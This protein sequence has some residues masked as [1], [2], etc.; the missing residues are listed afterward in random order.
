MS[1]KFFRDVL[2]CFKNDR[3][4]HAFEKTISETGNYGVVSRIER[5]VQYVFLGVKGEIGEG[6]EF[7]MCKAM[8]DIK[9]DARNEGRKQGRKEGLRIGKEKG[10][11]IG[12]ENAI[13]KIICRLLEKSVSLLE[14]CNITGAAEAMVS[15]VAEKGNYIL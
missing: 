4:K 13:R 12:E 5:L 11:K 1:C 15:E 10:I 9:R 3:D 7:D 14:I 8:M 6:E 2:N